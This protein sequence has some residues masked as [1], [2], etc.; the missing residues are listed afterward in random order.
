MTCTS[1]V[2][3]RSTSAQWQTM[4]W[5]SKRCDKHGLIVYAFQNAVSKRRFKT[6]FIDR[7]VAINT[8]WPG[9]IR[10]SYLSSLPRPVL[11]HLDTVS[12]SRVAHTMMI[13]HPHQQHYTCFFLASGCLFFQPFQRLFSIFLIYIDL[14]SDMHR[15]CH[16]ICA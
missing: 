9:S 15:R 3:L 14:S 11:A 12:G 10:S 13:T 7:N 5:C 8:H 16:R 6:P 2:K 1:H 4:E